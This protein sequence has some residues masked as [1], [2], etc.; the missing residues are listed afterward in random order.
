VEEGTRIVVTVV[1]TA[2]MFF[3]DASLSFCASSCCSCSCWISSSDLA[4]NVLPV[5]TVVVVFAL[6]FSPFFPT[7]STS[8]AQQ[9]PS[10]AAPSWPSPPLL[11]EAPA[12]AEAHPTTASPPTTAA[13]FDVSV[14]RRRCCCCAC[15]F[16]RC[17][18]CWMSRKVRITSG[19]GGG[20]KGRDVGSGGDNDDGDVNAMDETVFAFA[21]GGG[22]TCR[23]LSCSPSSSSWRGFVA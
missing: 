12:V 9:S 2:A 4:T 6:F 19:E 3:F 8:A 20:R 23:G 22:G 13:D 1:A 16:S 15:C 21:K 11:E 18:C 5:I 17:C 7:A 14:F 10:P